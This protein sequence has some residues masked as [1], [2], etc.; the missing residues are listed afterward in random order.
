MEAT[1]AAGRASQKLA[2]SLLASF[3]AVVL[4]LAAIGIYGVIAYTR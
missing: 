3:A 4:L 1:R 2:T